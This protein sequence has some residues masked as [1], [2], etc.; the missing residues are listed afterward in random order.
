MWNEFEKPDDLEEAV[1]RLTK[2]QAEARDIEL[3]LRDPGVKK[4]MAPAAYE[5][6]QSRALYALRARAQEIA[7]LKGWRRDRIDEIRQYVLDRTRGG[8]PDDPW[9]LVAA[10]CQVLEEKTSLPDIHLTSVERDLVSVAH[11]RLNEH[12]VEERWGRLER[13]GYAL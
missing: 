2:L 8:S 9:S 3:Q 7:F 5:D 11:H 12:F 1:R 13:E 6:W 10:L 4:K